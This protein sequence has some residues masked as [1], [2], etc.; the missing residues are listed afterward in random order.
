[1]DRLL[2]GLF[3]LGLGFLSYLYGV[4]SA[5]FGL[6]PYEIVRDAW[7]GGRA[8]QEVWAEE[9]TEMPPGSLSFEAQS[10]KMSAG[11]PDRVPEPGRE[12]ILMTGGPYM[13]MSECPELGCLAWIMDRAG[14]IYH[15]WP[16]DRAEPWGDMGRARGFSQ[17][18]DTYPEG[19]HLYDNGDLLVSYQVRG[20]FPYSVGLAKFDKNGKLLWKSES[21]THHWFYVDENGMIYAPSHE[22]IDSPLAIPDTNKQLVCTQGK[23]YRDTI[24]VL[25]P[26]GKVSGRIPLLQMLFESDYRGLVILTQD[27]CDPLHLNDVRLLTK[28]DA[29]AYPELAAGDMLVSLRNLNTMLVL[30]GKTARAKWAASGLTLRQHAPRFFGANSILAFDNEG[31]PLEKGG[32]RIV[33]I[34]LASRRMSTVFPRADTPPE[35]NFFS[36]IAGHIDL[37]ANRSRALVSLTMQGRVLEIDLATGQVLWEYDHVHDVSGYMES[38]GQGMDQ[39]FARFGTTGAYYVNGASFL[40]DDVEQAAIR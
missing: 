7:D 24:I 27:S 38:T 26:E 32:S 37:D 36:E 22:I 17:I 12:L 3:V 29:P 14:T 31:G 28:E 23:I 16:V 1:V 9:F 20:T 15:T 8:L 19:L 34:D 33:K 21:F 11:V 10:V 35:L 4:V 25:S 13:L 6:F 30:D 40:V 2:F 18:D 39:R 5:R